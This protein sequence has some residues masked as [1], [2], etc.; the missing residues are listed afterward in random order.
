[1]ILTIDIGTT[2]AKAAIF[3]SS[4]TM[5]A[6]SRLELPTPTGRT[7]LE[8]EI[9]PRTWTQATKRLIQNLG[10]EP[11]VELSKIRALAVSG[12]G[13]TIL[14][15]DRQ[16]E[17]LHD[18]LTWLDRRAQVQSEKVGRLLGYPLD[19][20][21]N[22]PKILW[23]KENLP[24]IYERTKWFVS[25]PEYIVAQL[26]GTYVSFLPAQG[27]TRIIWD[28]AALEK[29]SLDKSKF[30]VFAGLGEVVGEI[31]PRGAKLFGLPHGIPVVSG[32]PDFIAS[33]IGTATTAAGRACDR[34]GTS[35]GINLCWGG[36]VAQ[37]PRLLYM[38]HVVP[39]YQ[40]IS[41]VIST[42]GRA[43]TWFVDAFGGEMESHEDFFKLSSW[44]KPGADSLL[45]LPY[46]SGERAPIWDPKA[47]GAFIGL[48]LRHGKKEMAR[49]VAES[50]AFA[51]RDVIEVMETTGAKVSDLRVTGKPAANAILNQIKANI[52]GKPILV[53]EFLEA[54]LSG[55]L[56]L[57]MVALGEYG[58]IAQAAESHVTF[59]KTYEPEPGSK[60]LYDDLFGLYRKSYSALGKIFESLGNLAGS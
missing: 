11:N 28:D 51:M 10:R 18:A 33:L 53:P 47:R 7:S 40:N 3:T 30:P 59:G 2:S 49:A 17:V 1:M 15:V 14:S 41:G 44:A 22:L 12:Q 58:S 60:S 6:I 50:T 39:P 8:Q 48:T 56:C 57:A 21:F 23:I 46:L 19:A 34:S 42:T 38:P 4:G 37:D 9:P 45:F 26:T 29:L 54:E 27:Y 16:G 31:D 36:Q 55:D 13:P 43:V 24:E 35:E 32:G 20:A 5:V 52:T 25:C